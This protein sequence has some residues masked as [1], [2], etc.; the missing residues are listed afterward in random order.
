MLTPLG[1]KIIIKPVKIEEKTKSGI[2][3]AGQM[4]TSFAYAEVVAVGTGRE[5]LHGME[6]I[7]DIQPGDKI[8]YYRTAGIDM[9]WEGE[10]FLMITYKEMYAKI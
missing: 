10:S 8:M 7:N 3:L 4:A 1:D 2:V 9:R 5:T 6:P